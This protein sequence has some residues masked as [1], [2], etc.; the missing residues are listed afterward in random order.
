MNDMFGNDPSEEDGLRT[1][2][3]GAEGQFPVHGGGPVTIMLKRAPAQAGK[4]QE[5]EGQALH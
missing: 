5:Y 1:V 4:K 3:A 2:I